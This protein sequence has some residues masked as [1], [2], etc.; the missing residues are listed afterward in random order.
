MEM[1]YIDEQIAKMLRRERM[2]EQKEEKI[3]QKEEEKAQ[4]DLDEIEKGMVCGEC[5]VLG[6]A[7]VFDCKEILNHQVK[8]YL[9][10]KDFKILR[11][12]ADFYSGGDNAY[13]YGVNF[14][15]SEDE[16][17]TWD[18]YKQRM[19]ES[20]EK[21]NIHLKWLEEGCILNKGLKIQYI[22]FLTISGLGTFHNHMLM[23]NTKYGKLTSN[24]N[25]EQKDE[26][27][28]K[29]ITEVMIKNIEIL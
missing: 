9:P 22:E 26:K 24:L 19:K 6:Q 27:Y 16:M 28:W 3:K 2:K 10:N 12:F 13:G 11:S 25:Y 1:T 18:I 23:V 14:T 7:F 29:P 17:E 8:V 15:L 5:N 4:I 21:G 20:L